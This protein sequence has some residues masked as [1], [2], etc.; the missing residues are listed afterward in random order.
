MDPT[1]KHDFRYMDMS[2]ADIMLNLMGNL[3]DINTNEVLLTQVPLNQQ[4]ANLKR[5]L[6]ENDSNPEAKDWLT[7]NGNC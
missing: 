6:V 4:L 5:K 3:V 2:L 1:A 7:F